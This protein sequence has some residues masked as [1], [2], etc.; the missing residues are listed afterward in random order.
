MDNAHSE[1]QSQDYFCIKSFESK[2]DW[3]DLYKIKLIICQPSPIW[4]NFGIDDIK[5]F[6][7]TQLK[8]RKYSINRNM[9]DNT[10]NTVAN[11]SLM[12]ENNYL[13]LGGY[14]ID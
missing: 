9:V 5:I 13:N 2:V 10:T 8:E 3:S 4:R 14:I 12:V 11:I 7:K 1:F 6:P